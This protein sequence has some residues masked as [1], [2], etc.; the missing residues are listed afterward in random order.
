MLRIL[1]IGRILT[2][3]VIGLVEKMVGGV[4]KHRLL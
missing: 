2:V 1:V 4:Q 3:D